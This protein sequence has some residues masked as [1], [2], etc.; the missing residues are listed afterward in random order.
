MF[1]SHTAHLISISPN[2]LSS[3]P[4]PRTAVSFKALHLLIP[5]Q[6]PSQLHI[7]TMLPFSSTF[8]HSSYFRFKAISPLN[9]GTM[10]IHLDARNHKCST[11][12]NLTLHVV[13]IQYTIFVGIV[14]L[15]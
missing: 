11:L 1:Y 5:A 7:Y 10:S 6:K 4:P 15:C 14:V 8:I 2:P 13:Y 3:H 9:G 12:L